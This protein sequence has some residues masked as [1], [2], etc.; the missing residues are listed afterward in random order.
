MHVRSDLPPHVSC[1]A[2]G[3]LI[4]CAFHLSV[5][6][7]EG[8]P[9]L[10]ESHGLNVQEACLACSHGAALRKMRDRTL[11]EGALA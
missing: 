8:E 4:S 5:V 1:R 11:T 10:I 7:S 9:S 6:D 2:G 3:N